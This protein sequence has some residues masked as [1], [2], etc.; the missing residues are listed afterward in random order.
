[1]K[2]IVLAA[3]LTLAAPGLAEAK[4]KFKTIKS[5]GIIK[6]HFAQPPSTEGY[7]FAGFV[8]DSK[9]GEGAATSQGSIAG[10]NTSGG[11]IAFFDK[12]SVRG[13][14]KFTV[15]A[16]ADGTTSFE[17]TIKFKGGTGAYRGARGTGEMTGTQDAE[18][19]TSFEYTQK[20]KVP[21]K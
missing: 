17:G 7:A 14:F 20:V 4:Q 1:M 15:T 2:R 8:S 11:L 10:S 18:G 19:Y 21:K 9:L 5:S 12:G 16:N 3:V 6:G 13:S